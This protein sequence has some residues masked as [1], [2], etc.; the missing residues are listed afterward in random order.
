MSNEE[1]DNTHTDVGADYINPNLNQG[2]N[3][4]SNCYN[5]LPGEKL[6]KETKTDRGAPFLVSGIEYSNP[7]S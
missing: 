7:D 5:Q 2:V 1:Y 6:V 3:Y 4:M